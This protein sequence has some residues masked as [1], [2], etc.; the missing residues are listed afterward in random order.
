MIKAKR[1]W[2]HLENENHKEKGSEGEELESQI[3]KSILLLSH[4]PQRGIPTNA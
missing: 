4:V 1:R 2:I 3:M